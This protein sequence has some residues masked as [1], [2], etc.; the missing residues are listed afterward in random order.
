M[1]PIR[2][3]VATGFLIA[4]LAIFS[5]GMLFAE[6]KETNEQ[7]S[8]AVN[9]CIIEHS[10]CLAQCP[11][12]EAG[13]IALR[14]RGEC[15]TKYTLCLSAARRAP[16]G[17]PSRVTKHPSVAPSPK[18]TPRKISPDS[19]GPVSTSGTKTSAK[20]PTISRSS[21]TPAPKKK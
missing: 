20:E 11:P 8:V 13:P 12:A 17:D 4:G 16:K 15:D 14:R 7:K 5:V 3:Y 6:P 19:T 21:P 9:K 10:Q 18:P 1:K 2:L